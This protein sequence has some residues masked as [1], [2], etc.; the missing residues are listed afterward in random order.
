MLEL[1]HIHK[2]YQGKPLEKGQIRFVPAPGTRA[3][4]SGGFIIDGRYTI[5]AKILT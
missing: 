3:P 2:T 1:R 4:P 5:D